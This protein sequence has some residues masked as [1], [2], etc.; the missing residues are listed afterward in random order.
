MML[1]WT[2]EQRAKIEAMKRGLRL[3]SYAADVIAVTARERVL[4]RQQLARRL[5]IEIGWYTP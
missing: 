5:A 3:A 2:P 1:V 4:R